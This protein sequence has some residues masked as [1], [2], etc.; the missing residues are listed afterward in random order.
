MAHETNLMTLLILCGLLL[1]LHSR[2]HPILLLFSS[3]SF[4]ASLYTYHSA[5]VFVPLLVLLTLTLWRKRVKN[6]SGM[7]FAAAVLL[8]IFLLPLARQYLGGEGLARV[9][10]VSL[11][12]DPGVILKINEF[13]GQLSQEFSPQI[14]RF[15]SNKAT[16]Y[17]V[18]FLRNLAKEL[19]PRFLIL[20]GDPNGIYNT[21]NVGIMLW[22]EP[23]LII[24]GLLF[25][26]RTNR[27]IATWLFFG[28]IFGLIPDAL[29]RY[30][31]S[32]ARIHVLIPFTAFLAGVGFVYLSKKH[33]LAGFFLIFIISFNSWWFWNQYIRAIPKIHANTWQIG[34]K[35]MIQKT[36]LLAPQ[37][38]K[39]WISRSG[40]GWIHLVFHT[41]YDPQILQKEIKA[42]PRN[43]L[44]FW[45]V[46]DI[47]I[48]HLDWLPKMLEPGTLYIARPTEFESGI[49]PLDRV[50]GANGSDIYWFVDGNSGFPTNVFDLDAGYL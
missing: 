22:V 3:I 45:W 27:K 38:G 49:T 10:G 46:S 17:P 23:L 29:T 21:P 39:V 25:F 9:R 16:I 8:I 34:T 14:S 18:I 35:E 13:R 40:W 43:D 36:A 5:R 37:Y 20:H 48:Y 47:G 12:N 26:R 33:Y 31:P 7:W 11:W 28:L 50:R 24:A 19:D 42:S 4:A 44:G 32:S 2:K 41:K 1:I 15:I 6:N 30:G